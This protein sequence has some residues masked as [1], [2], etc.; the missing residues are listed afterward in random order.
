MVQTPTADEL[1]VI[2]PDVFAS[3]NRERIRQRD[4]L[5]MIASENYT[6]S[7]V[8]AAMGTILTNKYAE[9]YPGKR[10]YG[11]CEFVDEIETLA[12][13]RAK[14]LFGSEH[15]NVQP[16]SGAQANLA[17]Y[18]ALLKPGETAMGMDLNHGGHLTH[19]LKVN[20]S[21][22]WF[23]FVSYGVDR[24][25]EL[26][27]YDEM[28]TLA[29]EH[30]P[31]VIVIGAT[32]YPRQYDFALSAEIAES[33]GAVLM[34]D[35]AHISGLVASNLHPSP[36]GFCPVITLTT[37]KTLRGP[38]SAIILSDVNYAREIDKAVFPGTSGGPHMH[39]IAA[40][41]VAFREAASLE[42]KR[43]I[44]CVIEN[45]QVLAEVLR[46]EGFRLVSGGT[47][48]HLLLVDVGAQGLTGKAAEEALDISGITVNKNTIPFDKQK[49]TV[50]SGVRIGTPA[51]TTRGLGP[52]E[53][54]TIGRM[55]GQVLS[56]INDAAIHRTVRAEISDLLKP[57]PVP[58][59]N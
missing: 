25:S 5:E 53:M 17:A 30:R 43:Y 59:I 55:I 12:I 26:I 18:F 13:S 1:A 24:E 56:N 45:A 15:A 33:V 14:A 28:A 2:D 16:H 57:F 47:D 27:D 54:K 20:L 32:A 37:H 22:R 40:K 35:I 29:R 44:S 39:I 11:G 9:G 31:K 50:A 41:A 51:L 49:P 7:A 42:F 4:S 3:V 6:S 34:A 58:G 8:L 23:N 48:N 52:E 19:G 36:V 46:E 21:G 10:Y 38:R